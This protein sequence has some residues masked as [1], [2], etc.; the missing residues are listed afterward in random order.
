MF[1][2]VCFWSVRS[3][4]NW[5]SDHQYLKYH[6]QILLLSTI[7]YYVNLWSTKWIGNIA[8]YFFEQ[9][10]VLV[11]HICQKITFV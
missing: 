10:Q 2:Y 9:Y 3:W 7:Q 4:V 11:S 6:P 5:Y 8:T 1:Y